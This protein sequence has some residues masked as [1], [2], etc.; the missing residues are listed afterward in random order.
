V[1]SVRSRPA[2]SASILI[3]A[4]FAASCGQ[5]TPPPPSAEKPRHL[6]FITID[7]LRADRLGCYGHTSISTPNLDRLARE[8]TMALDESAHAP[9]TRPSHV[10][11]FTGLYPSQHGIRDNVSPSLDDGVPTLAEILR[12]NGFETAAF[13]SSVVLS[14]QSGFARGFDTYFD[15]FGL[16]SD[17]ARFLSSIQR[18]GG[19]VVE[20]AVKWLG[21]SRASR[22]AAW[23]HLY[24]P[25]DPYEPPEPYASRYRGRLY[26]G[27]VA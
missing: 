11:M 2:R 27:E 4:A 25:H 14:R 21:S 24:E 1:S 3:L 7:T 26:D 23:I 20:D 6:V 19:E 12:A 22:L 15:R 13:V 17:D 9:L 8:G 10:S 16:G 18:P 5:A